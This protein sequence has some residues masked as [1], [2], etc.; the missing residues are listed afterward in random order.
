MRESIAVASGAAAGVFTLATSISDDPA[1]Q[2]A[3]TA[4]IGALAALAVELVRY[5]LTKK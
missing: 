1:L 2:G 5:F 4:F 3:I